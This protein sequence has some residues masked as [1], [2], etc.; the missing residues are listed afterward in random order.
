MRRLPALLLMAVAVLLA[1]VAWPLVWACL[2]LRNTADRLRG[3]PSPAPPVYW[4]AP[5]RLVLPR[6]VI[7]EVLRQHEAAVAVGRERVH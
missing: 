1:C 2:W 7:E 6:C 3:Q 4:V 5:S